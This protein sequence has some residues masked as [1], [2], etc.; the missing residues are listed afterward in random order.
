MYTLKDITEKYKEHVNTLPN[1]IPITESIINFLEFGFEG[2]VFDKINSSDYLFNLYRNDARKNLREFKSE[3]FLHNH[4]QAISVIVN[5]DESYFEFS[6]DRIGGRTYKGHQFENNNVYS[7]NIDSRGRLFVCCVRSDDVLKYINKNPYLSK[8]DI[9]SN[10]AIINFTDIPKY[11]KEINIP[12]GEIFRGFTFKMIRDKGIDYVFKNMDSPEHFLDILDNY[13][14]GPPEKK[15]NIIAN[16][17]NDNDIT[18]LQQYAI[19]KEK[20]RIL[21]ITDMM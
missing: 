18:H 2:E 11:K 8:K 14:L 1:N 13:V 3:V 16:K 6:A 19:K 17:G 20:E 12:R 15:E 5:N 21:W 10:L 9:L 4:S 7:F